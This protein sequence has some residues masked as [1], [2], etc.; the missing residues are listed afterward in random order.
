MNLKKGNILL[1]IILTSMSHVNADDANV[2]VTN[3]FKKENQN[4][5]EKMRFDDDAFDLA[6][7]SFT[8]NGN[9][10][11]AF[12]LSKTAVA[13]HPEN[14]KWRE[15]LAQTAA[16]MNYSTI[17][18]DQYLYLIKQAEQHQLLNKA[19]A[20]G[21][22]TRRY[23]KLIPLYEHQQ[24]LEPHNQTVF[25]DL[26]LAYD[27]VGF[28]QRAITLLKNAEKNR[29]NPIF[30][31][32][33]ASIYKAGGDDK[34]ALE[35]VKKVK[36]KYGTNQKIAEIAADIYT[37]HAK[38]KEALK[39]L[40]LAA[41]EVSINKETYWQN[42][43]QLA[44]I[45][46]NERVARNAY[47]ELFEL[48]KLDL[49]GYRHLLLLQP[50]YISKRNLQLS[51]AAWDQYKAPDFYL[52]ALDLSRIYNQRSQLMRLYREPLSAANRKYVEKEGSYWR[53]GAQIYQQE[54]RPDLARLYFL[55]NLL[56]H[57]N[58]SV[59]FSYFNFLSAQLSLDLP[60]QQP[61]FL[62]AAMPTW[63]KMTVSNKDWAVAYSSAFLMLDEPRLALTTYDQA[64]AAF[65]EDAQ[66]HN[67]YADALE[68]MG[69][70]KSAREVRWANW[71]QMQKDIRE[72]D[73]D[74]LYFWESYAELARYFSP[75]QV[76]Y[77][78]SS[79]IASQVYKDAMPDA[80]L[81]YAINHDKYELALYLINYYYAGMPPS[82]ARTWLALLQN[83]R[84]RMGRMLQ[85]M[86]QALPRHDRV[87]MANRIDDLP[88][89]QTLAYQGL[90]NSNNR[91]NELY[92][93]FTDLMLRNASQLNI[94]VEYEQFGALQGPREIINTK[95]FINDRLSVTP[96]SNIWD[97]FTNN[98]DLFPARSYIDHIYG[99]K[100]MQETLRSMLTLNVGHRR[101][102]FSS[103]NA[104]LAGEY[105][106]TSKL[107]IGGEIGYNQR[108]TLTTTMLIAGSQDEAK[109][110]AEYHYTVRDMV[111]AQIEYDE[112]H[113]QNRTHLGSGQL[114]NAEWYHKFWLDY[115]DIAITPSAGYNRFRANNKELA[116]RLLRIIPD[117]TP[118]SSDSII[119]VNYWQ[120][121]V[122]FSI[123]DS[124][125]EEYTH[126]WR[127][128]AAVS[129]IYQS[130]AGWGEDID[131]GFTGSVWGR[132]K[133]SLFFERSTV[134]KGTEQTNFTIGTLYRLYF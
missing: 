37:N 3:P 39:E 109:L 114:I 123:G 121:A 72:Y 113:L 43:A 94:A 1:L 23:D 69:Y 60:R 96:Y 101:A 42:A 84:P 18:L 20:Y 35:T 74:D 117:H 46:G 130:S 78:L 105:Q 108:S 45:T 30:L 102:L 31:T 100:L 131:F 5:I 26:A 63:G 34:N 8:F 65:G 82:W 90:V 70:L 110:F 4:I 97:P 41:N 64:V 16:W 62:L 59:K 127:P 21:K 66:W 115:P 49:E 126:A 111:A 40:V 124:V 95:L 71:L 133:L 67:R 58:N 103:Y 125:K 80:L 118:T 12:A 57:Q 88:L 54:G 6:Y 50:T 36:N 119:P 9:V 15:R 122:R 132:D 55:K 17:A 24:K 56:R 79:Y 76:A 129:A 93:E 2:Y 61:A 98:R 47:N 128:Y 104:E 29:S 89:A 19:I 52:N 10:R 33:I 22:L 44:W 86:P 48:K 51:L 32:N 85:T 87:R 92:Q 13:Q 91:D 53:I 107:K 11:D 28:P 38:P 81:T 27:F 77:P 116:G 75:T 106:L 83:D 99:L 14:L 7:Q 120:T 25:V 68:A 112:Y 73:A 134:N